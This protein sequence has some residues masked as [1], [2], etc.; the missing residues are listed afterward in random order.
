MGNLFF[1]A[2]EAVARRNKV[3]A[4]SRDPS[5]MTDLRDAGAMTLKLDV[6][7]DD[8]T[9]VSAVQKIVDAHREVTHCVKYGRLFLEV[10]IKAA[11]REGTDH[12]LDYFFSFC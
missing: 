7:S 5:N 8:A 9:T 4:A 1:I 11:L 12:N 2:L 6:T 3:A 10:V